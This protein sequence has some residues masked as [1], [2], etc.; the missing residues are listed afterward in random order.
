MPRLNLGN[1]L[2]VMTTRLIQHV[3]DEP[4]TAAAAGTVNVLAML[5]ATA[6]HAYC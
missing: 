2:D 4:A 3:P 5:A 1:D 6:P